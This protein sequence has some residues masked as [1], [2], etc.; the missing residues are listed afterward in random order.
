MRRIALGLCSLLLAV[1]ACSTV[2]YSNRSRMILISEGQEK[3]MG[4]TSYQQIL[5]ESRLSSNAGQKDLVAR[6]GRR[7]AK[8]ANREDFQWEFNVID[9]KT[10]NA[11]CLP[12]GKV[13][14]YS[15]ILPLCQDENGVAVVMGH[16]VAHAL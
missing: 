4:L 1:V 14:F 9:S 13:A 11:F 7:I 2:P 12:G 5:S 15:G 3:E 8:V 6:C 16:E 10:V